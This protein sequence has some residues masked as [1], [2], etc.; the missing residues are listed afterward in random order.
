MTKKDSAKR[1]RIRRFRD[2]K[3]TKDFDKHICTL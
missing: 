3:Q 2:V 1:K